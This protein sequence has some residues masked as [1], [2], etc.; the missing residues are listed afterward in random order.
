M[1]TIFREAFFIQRDFVR[2]LPALEFKNALSSRR[3]I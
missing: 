3:E 2:P 1:A